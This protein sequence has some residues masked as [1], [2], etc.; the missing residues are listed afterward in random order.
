MPA[1]ASLNR[2]AVMPALPSSRSRDDLAG[3]CQ[4]RLVGNQPVAERDH[5]VRRRGDARVVRDQQERLPALAGLAKRSPRT[6][7]AAAESRLPV[8][9]SAS[10]T[11]GLFASARASATRC[12]CAAGQLCRGGLRPFGDSQVARA[13]RSRDTPGLPASAADQQQRQLDVLVGRQRRHQ[14]E[15]LEHEADLA[16]TQARE[17]VS[18]AR[19]S[20]RRRARPR[21]PSADRARRAG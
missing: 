9:S 14:V 15:E 18:S 3:R 6:S 17:L 10:T 7:R 19:R 8:G 11:S 2:S 13:A 16:T 21:P 4:L 5:P 12:C 1:N 20:D